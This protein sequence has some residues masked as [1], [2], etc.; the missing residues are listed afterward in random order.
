MAGGWDFEEIEREEKD[1]SANMIRDSYRRIVETAVG[2]EVDAI[3]AGAPK[4]LA[5][6]V[7]R[8]ALARMLGLTT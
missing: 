8:L 1:R 5:K 2:I 7:S 6:A 3:N 4:D